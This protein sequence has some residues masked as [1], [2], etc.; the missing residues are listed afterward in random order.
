MG[1]FDK[2][3]KS[4]DDIA[5]EEIKEVPWHPLTEMDQ[6]DNI[7]EESTGKTVVIFKHSTRC[8][9]SRMVLSNFEREFGEKETSDLKLYFLDLLANRDISGEVANRFNVRHESPQML[10][11]KEKT[12]VHH[13]S[14]HSVKASTLKE[15]I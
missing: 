4:E 5:K 7:E 13:S 6:L 9:I 2:I 11:I 1:L 15:H 14:H 8:G 10:I 3:F 12:V